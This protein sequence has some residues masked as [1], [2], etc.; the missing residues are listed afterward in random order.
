MYQK[1]RLKKRQY[2]QENTIC[3]HV[4]K[5]AIFIWSFNNIFENNRFKRS[6]TGCSMIYYKRIFVGV[7]LILKRGH[8]GKIDMFAGKKCL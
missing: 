7:V 4:H 5:V 1:S 8:E 6:C 2:N 3:Q